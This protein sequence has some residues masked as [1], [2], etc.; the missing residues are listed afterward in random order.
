MS[1]P[2]SSRSLPSRA[3]VLL[4]LAAGLAGCGDAAGG[5]AESAPGSITAGPSVT[6]SSPPTPSTTEARTPLAPEI[7]VVEVTIA[8]GEVQTDSDQV[9]V[10]S[11]ETV[12]VVVTSDVDDELHVHGV[13]QT[14]ELVGG[15]PTTIEFTVDEPG[16]FEVET[17]D[18]GRLLFQLLVR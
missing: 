12:R 14:A 9:E 15:E 13:D 6:P 18:D 16:V 8:D 1:T 17:H 7:R 3:M 4:V 2:P 11:G 10:A 5:S